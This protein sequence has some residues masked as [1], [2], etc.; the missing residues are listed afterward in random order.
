MPLP[1][2]DIMRKEIE[3]GKSVLPPLDVMRKEID[4]QPE[5]FATAEPVTTAVEEKLGTEEPVSDL[6]AIAQA[7]Y[8]YLIDPAEPMFQ[9]LRSLSEDIEKNLVKPE[10]LAAIAYDPKA[11][12][13]AEA[14]PNFVLNT[15]QIILGLPEF[16]ANVIENPWQAANDMLTAMSEQGRLVSRMLKGEDEA[17]AEFAQHP[18]EPIAMFMMARGFGRMTA[19]GLV[20]AEGFDVAKASKWQKVVSDVEKLNPKQRGWVVNKVYE[21]RKEKPSPKAEIEKIRRGQAGEY[22]T[23]RLRQQQEFE[24]QKV[25]LAKETATPFTTE[26]TIIAKAQAKITNLT[27]DII[28]RTVPLPEI[29]GGVDVA[30]EAMKTHDRWIRD[31]EWTSRELKR[32]GEKHIPKDRQMLMIHAYENK[33]KGRYWQQLTKEEQNIVRYMAEEKTKLNK[34]IDDNKILDRMKEKNINHIFHHWINPKSGVPYKAMYGKLSKGLPQAKQRYISTYESGIKKGL[35]PATTNP[36]ELIGLEWEAAARAL[37]TR[38]LTQTLHNIGAEKGVKI[39]LVPGKPVKPI[40]MLERWDL[41]EKQGL[42]DSYQRY[43]HYALDK[44]LTFTDAEGALVKIK[45]AVGIRKE[46]YPFVKAY[47][48]SPQ[49]TLFDQLNFATKSLK[50]GFSLF[51]V[52]SLAAQE[53]A[54]WRIPF[55]NIPRGLKAR[56]DLDPDL[57]ILHREGLDLFKGYEDIGYR[58]KFFDGEGYM[59]KVGNTVTKPIEWM[60]T[61]IFDVVQPGMKTSFALDTYQKILPKYIE[62]GLTKEQAARD[63]VKAADGHFSHE[64]YKRSLLESNR[65]MVKNYFYPEARKWWQRA[66]LSPTWQREHLLVAKN[67]AKS[68]LPDK[69]IKKLGLEEVGAIKKE[70]R[71]YAAGALAMITAVDMYNL[72]AT[73]AMDGEAKHI[74]ENPEGKGFSARAMW[75]EPSYT[76]TTRDGKERKITG[77]AAYFRPLKS[78]YEVAEWGKD[79]I[80]KF[81][82]KLSPTFTAVGK[83]LFPSKYRREYEGLPDIPRRVKDLVMDTSTPIQADQMI[84]YAKGKKS[85][86]SAILP[87]VGFPTSKYSYADMKRDKIKELRKLAIEEHKKTE[88][89]VEARKWNKEYPDLEIKENDYLK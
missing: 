26:P 57:R 39:Q 69:M 6:E 38:K 33:M 80:K 63:A 27:A 85:I 18:A 36:F 56:R 3:E 49:Y 15:G 81:S 21:A 1:S 82:Y 19:K 5:M 9:Y 44:T 73:Q 32:F 22:E 86:P 20:K 16:A 2:L 25:K 42:T 61:F 24:K 28:K 58:N 72:M 71:K 88:A 14:F 29:K 79:P 12:K 89:K 7:R 77:G 40:R 46:L 74:W 51:H 60:R 13:G 34:F 37:N 75:N 35:V 83:Q 10:D 50:L 78:V 8:K 70:Y 23:E 30:L 43:S 54:N 66:L 76:I 41:L 11:F 68:F 62:K 17:W 84:S 53:T 55:K 4:E 48:E 64:H 47:V 67:V 87:F 52:F 31:A 45:G 65:W 59:T